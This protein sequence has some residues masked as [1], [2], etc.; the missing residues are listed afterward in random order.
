MKSR[1]VVAGWRGGGN[2]ELVW[3]RVPAAEDRN[4]LE[5]DG[6]DGCTTV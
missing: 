5:I 4:L 6:S 2:G 1:M 3:N